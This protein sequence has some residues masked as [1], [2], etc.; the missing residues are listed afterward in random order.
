M[1]IEGVVTEIVGPAG[2]FGQLE[3]VEDALRD[4]VH[5]DGLLE[6]LAVVGHEYLVEPELLE[7]APGLDVVV[8][9]AVDDGGTEDGRVGEDVQ[10]LLLGDVLGGEVE[11]LGV[12]VRAG[13][14]EVD[15]SE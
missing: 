14:G 10:H 11:R 3:S 13:R 7:D 9:T 12:C 15:Q 1:R 6:R 8:V 2:G 4:V 5:E